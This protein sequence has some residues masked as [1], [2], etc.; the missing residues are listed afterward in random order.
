MPRDAILLG[1][2]VLCAGG[3]KGQPL[4]CIIPYDFVL[5][6]FFSVI[7]VAWLL[8]LQ[9]I[10]P[11]ACDRLSRCL[12]DRHPATR[13]VAESLLESVETVIMYGSF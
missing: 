11:F 2:L 4:R 8:D 10:T 9:C 13:A 12:D 5:L 3:A 1:A 6:T 7:D